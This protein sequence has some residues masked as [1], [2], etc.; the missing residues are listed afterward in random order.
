MIKQLTKNIHEKINEEF[1]F[2]L[3]NKEFPPNNIYGNPYV[4][5]SIEIINVN[6]LKGNYDQSTG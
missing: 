6:N 5:S 3:R 1:I 2:K 4:A